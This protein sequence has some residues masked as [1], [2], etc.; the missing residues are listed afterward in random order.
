LIQEA[1]NGNLASIDKVLAEINKGKDALKEWA[2][3]KFS[4]YFLSTED[5]R[6]ILKYGELMRWVGTQEKNYT[7]NAVDEFMKEDNADPW[8][9]AFAMIDLKLYTIVTF[10]K[11]HPDMKR[12][13]PIPNVCK[14][15]KVSYTDL[16]EMLR[17]L[18]LDFSL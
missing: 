12:K 2:N 18:V 13:I 15:F 16:F 9:I 7:S 1:E 3:Q 5:K 8:L 11:Y 14:D 4:N 6:V 17:N 10:E